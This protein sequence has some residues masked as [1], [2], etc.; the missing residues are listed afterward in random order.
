VGSKGKPVIVSTG[1]TTFEETR[2]TVDAI[3]ATGAPLVLMHCTSTYPTAPRDVRLGAMVRLQRDN[4]GVPVGLSDH[5][6]T[7]YPAL[8]AVALGARVIEKHF[9]VSR[10][11]DGPDQSSSLEPDEMAALV[12]GVSIVHDAIQGS[13][14]NILPQEADVQKMARESIVAIRDIREGETLSLDN[15]WVKRPG[16]GIPA[17]HFSAV[18]GRTARRAIERDVLLAPD[19]FD[20]AF[21]G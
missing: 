13:D 3:K 5:S 19:D 18:L 11:W 14:K 12:E 4:P 15:V 20:P 7:I 21:R 8:G 10:A 17:R 6:M 1:M 9:T 16:T 2:L